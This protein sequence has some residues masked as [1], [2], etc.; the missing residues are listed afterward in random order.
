MSSNPKAD[1]SGTPLTPRIGT[2]K[3]T[4]LVFKQ[5]LDKKT[6]DAKILELKNSEINA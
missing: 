2:I 6:A 5:Y 3:T 1:Y 4:Q